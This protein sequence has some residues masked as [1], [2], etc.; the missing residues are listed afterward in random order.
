MP[1]RLVDFERENLQ[2]GKGGQRVPLIIRWPGNTLEATI[3][4]K[5]ACAIDILPTVAAIT[6]GKLSDNKIDG[7]DITS[8]WKGD[9]KSEPRVSI[10]YNF[11]KNNLNGVRK[12]DPLP[13]T[14][15]G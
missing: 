7:V 11:G 1:A 13:L 6:K 8:L 4:N 12:G 14:A 15:T 10:L 5:L 2:A 9:F 3:C